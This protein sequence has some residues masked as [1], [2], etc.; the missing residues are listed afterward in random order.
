MMRAVRTW[1]LVAP[2]ALAAAACGSASAEGDV[3]F[4]DQLRPGS[5]DVTNDTERET[6][7]R[8]SDLPAGDSVTIAGEQVTAGE[9]YHAASG[10]RCR[11]VSLGGA[12]RLACEQE[13]GW[14]FVPDVFGAR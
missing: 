12:A 11:E 4:D 2:V 6:L 9:P 3:W 7:A 5:V 10:R 8:L 14:V 1:M 13:Q